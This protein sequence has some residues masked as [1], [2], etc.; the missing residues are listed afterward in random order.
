MTQ[1]SPLEK[2]AD[3]TAKKRSSN[4]CRRFNSISDVARKMVQT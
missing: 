4:L 1:F 3:I 2:N